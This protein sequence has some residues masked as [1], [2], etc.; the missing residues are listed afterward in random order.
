M[1]LGLITSRLLSAASDRDICQRAYAL[2]RKARSVA[3]KWIGELGSKLDMTEDKT[4]STNLRRRLS[5]LAATCLSTYD[6]CL[7]HVPW[8]LSSDSDIAIAVHCAVVV[9]DNTPLSLWLDDS[10]YLTRLM[11]RHC[12]LLHFLEPF[13]RK[14]VQSNP[15]GFDQ[16]LA[17]L[18]PSFRRQTASN[19]QVL[20]SPNSRWTFSIAEGGQE[21]HYNILTG[22]LL[23]GGNPL[24]RLP[25]GIIQ[26]STYASI[27]G[28]VS[29][30]IILSHA[31]SPIPC[32][33]FSM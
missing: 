24:G 3:H 15:S 13:L 20:P 21:V 1:L 18:W 6:V 28:K 14:C 33:G 32:R 7:E 27:L 12:R 16:G 19:W 5:I 9:F 30:I 23:I 8:T 26:H 22:Q 29:V 11:N 4:S 31:Y 25:Q 10:R 2:L 17:S